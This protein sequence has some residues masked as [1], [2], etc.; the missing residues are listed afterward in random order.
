MRAE[1]LICR[2]AGRI[3]GHIVVVVVADR[4]VGKGVG[5]VLA[6]IGAAEGVVVHR[7]EQRLRL[8]VDVARRN[9]VSRARSWSWACRSPG[10]RRVADCAALA[11]IGN[12]DQRRGGLR[13]GSLVIGLREIAL[14]LQQRGH[15]VILQ[16]VG[17]SD[18][19]ILDGNEEE[20][21]VS[22]RC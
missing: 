8:R 9:D 16:A 13:R 4:Q 5:V 14:R 2:L 17:L 11:R 7:G 22:C 3:V 20:K 6:Q 15:G 19:R 10:N 1:L 12:V 21:L 18:G